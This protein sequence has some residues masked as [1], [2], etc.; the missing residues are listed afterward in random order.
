METDEENRMVD[1]PEREEEDVVITLTRVPEL[2]SDVSMRWADRV[3]AEDP[4]TSHMGQSSRATYP[5]HL[6]SE[7]MSFNGVMPEESFGELSSENQLRLSRLNSVPNRPMS[8][9]F[10]LADN[11]VDSK[12]ILDK[13]ITMGIPRTHVTCIQRFRSGQVDVTF[14]KRESRE[15]FL[16]KVATT[17]ERRPLAPR[18][19]WQSGIFVTVRDAPWELPDDVIKQRLEKYGPVYSIRRAFNQ[20]LLPEKVP[21]GRRVL[22][23]VVRQPI[24]PFMKF[25]PFLVRIFYPEQPRVCWKCNSPDHI[26]R[27]CPEDYC[28]NCDQ[29]GHQS[30]ACEERIKCSL[31][32]SEEHLAIDCPGNWGRR[33]LAE[34]TPRREEDTETHA[35][36]EDLG[37][38]TS[39]HSSEDEQTEREEDSQTDEN[40]SQAE[41]AGNTVDMDEDSEVIEQ[42]SSSEPDTDPPLPQRKRG[43]RVEEHVKKKSR[44]EENPLK[45]FCSRLSLL[46]YEV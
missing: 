1:V 17:F 40:D 3:V 30:H 8:A 14:A 11:S 37:S 44:T 42:F 23:M 20:S 13:I 24:P 12:T 16:S 18:P 5:A 33:T 46:T 4:G 45:F 39:E 28:F 21:D 32:K 35:T 31:C 25:G 43:G 10:T 19:T 9:R 34:R 27:A 15:L 6:V 38:E 29:T 36:D 26:G 7:V 2:S 22:R 41:E